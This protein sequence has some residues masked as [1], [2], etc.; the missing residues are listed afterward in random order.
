MFVIL[1]NKDNNKQFYVMIFYYKM[2]SLYYNSKS[3]C[4]NNLKLYAELNTVV[5]T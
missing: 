3:R 5:Y 1:Q 2:L 4:K